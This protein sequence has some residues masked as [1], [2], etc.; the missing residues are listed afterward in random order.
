VDVE[1]QFAA[2]VGDGPGLDPGADLD[3]LGAA[4]F[5]VVAFLALCSLR[6]R[7]MATANAPTVP[8]EENRL[9]PTSSHGEGS[10]GQPR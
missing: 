2:A 3:G 7:Y 1:G 10:T 9:A 4:G 6:S 5:L 8:T